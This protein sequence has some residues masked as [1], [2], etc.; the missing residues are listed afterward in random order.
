VNP[1]AFLVRH[2]GEDWGWVCWVRA[3]RGSFGRVAADG[4]LS[5]LNPRNTHR[6]WGSLEADPNPLAQCG[7]H[8]VPGAIQAELPE[9]VVD[10]AP[11]Q[12]IV[13]KQTPRAA[14]PYDIEDG[15]GTDRPA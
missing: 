5:T 14:A 2:Q 10:A 13:G 12:E 3:I 8:P 6:G 4:L 11:R 9:V 15:K 1:V 7:V